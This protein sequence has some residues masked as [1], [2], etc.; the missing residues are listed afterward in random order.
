MLFSF[1]FVGSVP[2]SYAISPKIKALITMAGY[3][4]GGGALLGLAS[5]AFGSKPITIAQGASLGLY[6]G[7]IFGSYIVF[8]YN[9]QSYLNQNNAPYPTGVGPYQDGGESEEDQRPEE[10]APSSKIFNSLEDQW[11]VEVAQLSG[12]L[13]NIAKKNDPKDR[14]ININFFHYE[15]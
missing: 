4:A 5:M 2:N 13:K 11:T 15:F 7:L 10:G 3:G 1:L 12:E 8:T 6:A 14:M 9:S